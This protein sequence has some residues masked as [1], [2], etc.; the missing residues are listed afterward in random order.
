MRSRV[1]V[2]GRDFHWCKLLFGGIAV[3]LC[4]T[5]LQNV[6][7]QSVNAGGIPDMPDDQTGYFFQFLSVANNSAT[8]Y[9]GLRVLVRDI[10]A[11]TPTNMIRVAN[12]HGLTNLSAT[13]TNVPYFDFGPITAGQSV[14][15]LV[16]WYIANRVQKPSPT[17][18]TIVMPT[19]VFVVPTTMLVTNNATRVVEGKFFA[20]FKSEEGRAYYIQYNSALTAT[21]NWKTSLPPVRGSGA[22]VQWVDTGPPRT[23]SLPTA[24]TQRFYRV[25][26]VPE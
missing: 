14:P 9:P 10:P 17:F 23:E 21:N 18:Q 11:D 8:N 19:P 24:T 15:F 1:V 7:A 20:E 5:L 25:I 2:S 26:V 13:I 6:R 4:A 22:T 3:L 12:A 16:E